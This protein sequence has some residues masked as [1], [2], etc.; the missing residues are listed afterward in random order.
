[1]GAGARWREDT[2]Y[3]FTPGQIDLIESVADEVH[4]LIRAGVRTAIEGRSAGVLG[5]RA[6]VV[7]MVEASWADHWAGGR[8]DERAGGLVGRLTFAYDGRDSLKLLACN[9]DLPDGLFAAS[10]MQWNWRESQQPDAVQFNG[11]H[12]ALVER[13]E[14]ICRGVPARDRLHLTCLTP[15]PPREG[16]L[17]Y[18]SATAAEAR[19]A[20]TLL[21]IQSI[22]WDGGRF[23]D[24]EGGAIGWLAKLYPWEALVDDPFGQHLRGGGLAVVEPLWRWLPSLH[25]FL[26]ILSARHPGHP[27]LCPAAL[28]AIGL[29]EGD[30]MTARSGFGLDAAPTRMVEQ[31]RVVHDDGF[32]AEGP[33]V[34]FETPPL[35]EADGM[36]AVIDAWIVGDK[37][38]GMSVR[39]AAAPWVGA[40]AAIVPHVVRTSR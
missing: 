36:R 40:D 18:L 20:S 26:A 28:T 39:E 5:L 30:A 8:M 15:D 32:T 31:G 37:C 23:R 25:G 27:N 2:V 29:G 17:V 24:T 7:R 14:E 3:E 35:F 21:P 9:Y 19:I 10:M 4:G 22:G 11:L 6:D 33:S 13:W 1:M 34:W 16:E 38:M 12:E